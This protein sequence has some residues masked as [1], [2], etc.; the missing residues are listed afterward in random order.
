[1]TP[2]LDPN[3]A[4]ARAVGAVGLPTTLLVNAQGLEIAR[5]QGPAEWDEP[6]MLDFLKQAT[7]GRE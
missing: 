7:A 1:M 5:L 2:Y 4:F 6:E 3:G